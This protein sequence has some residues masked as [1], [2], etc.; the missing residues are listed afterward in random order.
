[1]RLTDGAWFSISSWYNVAE[2]ARLTINVS[3]ALGN[4]APE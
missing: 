1:M 3:A 4:P 2:F